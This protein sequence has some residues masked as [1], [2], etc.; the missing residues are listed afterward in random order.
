MPA[1][2][3]ISPTSSYNALWE[4][5]RRGDCE[6]RRG[7]TRAPCAVAEIVDP[8]HRSH[9]SQVEKALRRLL[10]WDGPWWRLK[11]ARTAAGPEGVVRF[12]NGRSSGSRKGSTPELDSA[13]VPS[14]RGPTGCVCLCSSWRTTL[15][16]S[17]ARLCLPKAVRHW[18]LR[19]SR[20]EAVW[21]VTRGDLSVLDLSVGYRLRQAEGGYNHDLAKRESVR[22]QGLQC[23]L[24]PL[25]GY[26][27]SYWID[28]RDWP[29]RT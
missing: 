29:C 17:F 2:S 3:R 24:T 4:A 8:N 26:G 1:R 20:W 25:A 11:R 10:H 15:G 9:I 16:T 27:I 5:R 22:E 14:V 19:E 7:S 13:V 28:R 6:A 21:C 23:S 12:Y 18:S